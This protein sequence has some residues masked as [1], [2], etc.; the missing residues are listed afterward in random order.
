MVT[1]RLE[2]LQGHLEVIAGAREGVS[3]GR[4]GR[5]DLEEEEGRG[6]SVFGRDLIRVVFTD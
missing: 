3:E 2:G 6:F 4:I 1:G 5:L